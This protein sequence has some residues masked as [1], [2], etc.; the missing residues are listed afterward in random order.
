MA[1]LGTLSDNAKMLLLGHIVLQFQIET[2]F[3]EFVV[4]LSWQRTENH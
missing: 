2:C 1:F 3:G 4:K